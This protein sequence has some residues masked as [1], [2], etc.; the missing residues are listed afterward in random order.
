MNSGLSQLEELL[1]FFKRQFIFYLYLPLIC[2]ETLKSP[3]PTS[4]E[5]RVDSEGRDQKIVEQRC[6]IQELVLLF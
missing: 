5:Q 1:F 6:E 3:F 4:G 2:T